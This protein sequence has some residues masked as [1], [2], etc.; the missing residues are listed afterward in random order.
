MKSISQEHAASEQPLTG[1][2]AARFWRAGRFRG[3]ECLSA[4]F[5]THEYA[6]HT[7][8]TFS[9][10][11]IEKGSQIAS[12]RGEREETGPGGLY[13]IN[14]DDIH[15]GAPG[16]SGYR[17]RMV[18]PAAELFADILEDV[19]GREL[20]GTPS[21]S[22]RLVSDPELAAAFHHAHRTMEQE[23]GRLETDESMFR[24]LS[25]IFVRH[26]AVRVSPLASRESSAARR[27]R[28]YIDAHY[29]ND[30]G[31]EELAAVAGLSRAH[32][33]RSFRREFF[34][35]P[36]AFLT[37]IRIRQARK[38]LRAGQTPAEVAMACGFAD[39]AHLTRHFK[40]RTGVTPG[41]FRGAGR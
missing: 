29:E 19:S 16:E 6:P 27:V 18:Y 31:L 26:G 7:H 40:A 12:I 30:P 33:I 35:T 10:G 36:H 34:T 38:R 9:I 25:A 11:A 14:P 5:H 32:M 4:T 41:Q 37:D 8:D 28:D 39:Q 20:K 21:F 15:D 1:M 17:Y 3:M 23:T 22:R 13:L 2:E 24:L